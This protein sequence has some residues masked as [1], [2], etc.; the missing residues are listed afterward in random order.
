MKKIYLLSLIATVL[1]IV[2]CSKDGNVGPAGSQ[3]PTGPTGATGAQGITGA[4]GTA[5]VIYSDWITPATYVKT[6]VFS[7]S[8]FTYN[9]A[10]PKIT[11]DILDKGT[12]V[13]F[14]KLNG[15]NPAIW[16]TD[17]VS[18]MP[19]VINY[20][21]GTTPEIDIWSG[22]YSLGSIQISM[23]NNN[24]VY[25]SLAT[26]HSFRYVIIPGG[27]KLSLATLNN[28]DELKEQLH[29]QD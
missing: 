28:Y 1:S 21:S 19:I 4:S 2:S 15:Y 25:G 7:T 27:V 24:N 18:I 23:K 20:L 22:V 26:A 5:N 29:M 8:T 14:G 9:I 17:Q 13:V 10:E 3:G 12:V 6:T 16:P 11:Q